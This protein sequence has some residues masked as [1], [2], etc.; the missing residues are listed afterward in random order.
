MKI[1]HMA[2]TAAVIGLGLSGAAFAEG[3]MKKGP[4]TGPGAGTPPASGG[5]STTGQ[6]NP[7]TGYPSATGSD[8]RTTP[9]NPSTTAASPN[10]TGCA[11]VGLNA[12]QLLCA[13]RLGVADVAERVGYSSASTFST[14]FS[15]HVGVPPGRFARQG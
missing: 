11:I 15:R 1:R 3:D 8:T 10:A 5:P 13:G 6:A 2:M 4:D 9:G 12:K 7:S 14:A